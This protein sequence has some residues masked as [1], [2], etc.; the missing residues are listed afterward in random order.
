MFV[1][2]ISFRSSSSVSAQAFTQ[3]QTDSTSSYYNKLDAN[4]EENSSGIFRGNKFS[5]QNCPPQNNTNNN[6]NNVNKSNM[7]NSNHQGANGL[8]SISLTPPSSSFSSSSSSCSS[9]SSISM[10]TT[11]SYFTTANQNQY[12][13]STS[14]LNKLDNSSSLFSPSIKTEST[15]RFYT[16]N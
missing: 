12:P 6:N 2:Y 5:N 16:S 9:T 8:S 10:P 13:A 4:S 1:S 7:L 11:T 14:I 3:M 15:E